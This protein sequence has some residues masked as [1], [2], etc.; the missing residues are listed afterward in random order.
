MKKLIIAG[1]AVLISISAI[2]LAASTAFTDENSFADWYKDSVKKLSS[3]GIITG[4]PDGSFG[5]SNNVN[6]AE[7]AVILAR[8]DEHVNKAITQNFEY[9]IANI[10]AN[11]LKLSKNANLSDQNYVSFSY[12]VMAESGFKKLARPPEEYGTIDF[13]QENV[14]LPEG[15][16]LYWV[17]LYPSDNPSYLHFKGTVCEGDLCG[18]E[19][20]QWYGPFYPPNSTIVDHIS[21]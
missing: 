8:L 2:A 7:L 16:T 6:R 3:D 9:N 17:S 21:Q 1:I 5:P 14:T 18:I 12:L 20:D 11:T 19:K 4:Y 15:Y 10:I 13:H